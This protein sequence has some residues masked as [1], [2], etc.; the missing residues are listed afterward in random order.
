MLQNLTL[1]EYLSY[2]WY[3]GSKNINKKEPDEVLPCFDKLVIYQMP[4]DFLLTD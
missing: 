2:E 4:D 1:N 3:N